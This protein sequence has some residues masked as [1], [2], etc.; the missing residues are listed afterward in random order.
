M[1]SETRDQIVIILYSPEVTS[2]ENSWYQI[3]TPIQR[4]PL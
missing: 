4:E 3:F 2:W 1:S